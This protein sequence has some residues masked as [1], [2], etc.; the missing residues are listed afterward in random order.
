MKHLYFF[1]KSTWLVAIIC[2]LTFSSF[3]GHPTATPD[4]SDIS[5]TSRIEDALISAKN[6]L[7]SFFGETVSAAVEEA[8]IELFVNSLEC[9]LEP[10]WEAHPAE[11]KKL[12]ILGRP[13]PLARALGEGNQVK[14]REE[15]A[16]QSDSGVGRTNSNTGNSRARGRGVAPST[17]TAPPTGEDGPT[18]PNKQEIIQLV[19]G[20]DALLIEASSLQAKNLKENDYVQAALDG[21]VP[22]VMENLDGQTLSSL[23]GVGFDVK[24]GIIKLRRNGSIEMDVLGTESDLQ[25]VANQV[26]PNPLEGK[27]SEKVKNSREYQEAVRRRA[28]GVQEDEEPDV[29]KNEPQFDDSPKLTLED[30]KN[31]AI[32]ILSSHQKMPIQKPQADFAGGIKDYSKGDPFYISLTG[33]KQTTTSQKSYYKVELKVQL[34]AASTQKYVKVT[35]TGGS[36][37]IAAASGT[38]LT[39]NTRLDKGYYTDQVRV[40]YGPITSGHGLVI[41][42]ENPKSQNNTGQYI[43]SKGFT[44][45]ASADFAKDPSM[46]VNASYSQTETSVQ[47]FTDFTCFNAVENNYA[48]F[49]WEMTQTGN[50]TPYNNYWDLRDYGCCDWDPGLYSLPTM[51]TGSLN[52]QSE[53][54][55]RAPKNENR[56]ITFK[57]YIYHY[58]VDFYRTRWKWYDFD[59]G[60]WNALTGPTYAYQKTFTVDFSSVWV[61]S[62]SAGRPTNMSSI[63]SSYRW[64]SG[65]AVDGKN[66]NDR[67]GSS[68][69]T[70]YELNPWW[71]VDL[72]STRTIQNIEVYD[73]NWTC[74]SSWRLKDYYIMLANR[75]DDFYKAGRVSKTLDEALAT[76]SIKAEFFPGIQNGYKKY[77]LTGSYNNYRYVRIWMKGNGIIPLCEVVVNRP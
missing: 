74:C 68:T 71:E 65:R 47:N 50:S 43:V 19:Q 32:E 20:A 31:E 69:A 46:G 75:E 5:L 73:A 21:G 25:S 1:K 53:V 44:V 27:K 63:N 77:N 36:K 24:A 54:V 61:P 48:K 38:S 23:T 59:F 16:P 42:D 17:N 3:V 70:K 12:L 2:F 72:E 56:K 22:I 40:E 66:A 52:P 26:E 13:G 55:W 9:N 76:P 33:Y 10:S 6:Y 8:E 14:V 58:L 7:Q 37:F 60:H 41:E 30:V 67:W 35:T 49:R 4:N 15:E 29:V 62:L 18:Q 34:F 64:E 57:L 28:R 51:A 11:G 39:W 45:G